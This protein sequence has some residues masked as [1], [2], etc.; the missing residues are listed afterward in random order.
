MDFSLSDEQRMIADTVAKVTEAAGAEL[1]AGHAGSFSEDRWQRLAET[2]LLGLNVPVEMGGIGGNAVDNLVALQAFGRG[3][4]PEPV[5]SCAV[6]GAKL[7]ALLGTDEQRQR[8]FPAMAEGQL[9]F[10]L[11]YLERGRRYDLAP[12]TTVARKTP[13]GWTLDGEKVTV[14]DAPGMTLLAVTAAIL[15][16]VSEPRLGV[17]LLEPDR[18][19]MSLRAGTTLD[20]RAFADVVL[21]KVQCSA[22]ALLGSVPAVPEQVMHVLDWATAAACFEAVGAMEMLLRITANYIKTRKQFGQQLASFQA[23]Q[24]RVADMASYLEQARSICL[25]VASQLD[26]DDLVATARA[27][28]AAKVMV[29]EAARFI[30]QQAVQLHGAIG[31]TEE[32]AVSRYFKRLTCFEMT[33]GD[34]DYHLRRYQQFGRH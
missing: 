1:S 5:I 8:Y 15:D 19:G 21:E 29:G 22:D 12:I 9:R 30:G 27:T 26:G 11:A 28:S 16:G 20:G 17:F 3:A 34:A 24:H 23:I 6:V 25:H 32:L 4:L 10:V 14:L 2:G 33:F 7:L 31:I 18:T 13:N